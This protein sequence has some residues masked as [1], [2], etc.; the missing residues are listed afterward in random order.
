MEKTEW[1]LWPTQ[2]I[3]FMLSG[4]VQS[5]FSYIN[6]LACSSFHKYSEMRALIPL[7]SLKGMGFKKPSLIIVNFLS[8]IMALLYFLKSLSARDT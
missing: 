1:T 2:F 5:T 8:V 3:P 4:P 7:V 6:S